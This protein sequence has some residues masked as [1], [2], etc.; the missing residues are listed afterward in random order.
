MKTKTSFLVL[1]L[2]FILSV[3]GQI[4]TDGLVGYWP[5]NGNANDESGNN[6]HGVVFGATLTYDRFGNLNSAYKFD[7]NYIAVSDTSLFDFTNNNNLSLCA[8]FRNTAGDVEYG[9]GIIAKNRDD[10][11]TRCGIQ[12]SNS[13]VV[14][15]GLLFCINNG[16]GVQSCLLI[17]DD[18]YAQGWHFVIGTYDC[19]KQKLYMD[20]ILVDSA[21]VN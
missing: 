7:R 15:P 14:I 6:N 20:G 19:S 16:G 5:F 1:M 17:R 13:S 3:N 10:G 8:W 11:G 9:Q 4:P 18:V 2:G 21:N 12:F